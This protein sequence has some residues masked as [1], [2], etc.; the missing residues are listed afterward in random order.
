M[1]ITALTYSF[2]YMEPVC[3]SM[4][5]SNLLSDLHTGFSRG[6]SGGLVCPSPSEFSTVYLYLEKNMVQEDP[7]T[8]MFTAT[9]FTI[10]KT[11]KQP[12]SPLTEEWIK[13]WYIYTMEYRSAIK[14]EWNNGICCNMYGP[15]DCHTEWSKSERKG[16]LSWHHLYVESK[17]EMIQMISFTK[18][19]HKL[20]EWTYDCQRGRIW[21]RDS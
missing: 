20:R 10:A 11:W 2:S 14:K 18:Q 12:K 21:V 1:T 6:R 8:P 9:L 5:S 7:C 17:K 15:R 4:S 13:M 3:C 19:T 16:E